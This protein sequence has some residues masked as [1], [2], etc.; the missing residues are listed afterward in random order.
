MSLDPTEINGLA[1]FGWVKVA[2]DFSDN[3]SGRIFDAIAVD[4]P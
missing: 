3:D 4:F 2:S 1:V